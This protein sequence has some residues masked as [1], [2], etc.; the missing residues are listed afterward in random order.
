MM[1]DNKG[2]VSLEYILIFTV[3]LIL[4]IVFTM[5]LTH[6]AIENTMDVSDTLEVKSDLSKIANAI[7]KVYGQG[8]GSKQSVHIDSSKDRKINIENN[9]ISSNLKLADSSNKVEKIYFEST[10]PKS[11]LYISKGKNKITVEWPVNSENMKIYA[12]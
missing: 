8:Q 2:Q 3:S 4:L 12:K 9:Y 7:E 1:M 5:P 10:L 11:S 6:V